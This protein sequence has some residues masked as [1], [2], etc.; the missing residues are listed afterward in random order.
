MTFI[1]ILL[2]LVAY[3]YAVAGIHLFDA[4]VLPVDVGYHTC[5]CNH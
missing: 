1:M 2:G 4:Y 3:I 5:E